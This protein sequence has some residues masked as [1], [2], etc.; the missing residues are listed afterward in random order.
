M[1]AV[2]LFGSI[3][4]LFLITR[5]LTV[6]FHELGHGIPALLLTDKTVTLYVGSYGDP[7]NSWRFKLGR[8]ECVFRYNPFWKIGMCVVDDTKFSFSRRIAI[9]LLGPI[10][11][12]VLGISCCYMAISAQLHGSIKLLSGALFLSCLL[13]FLINII[14][15]GNPVVLFDGKNTYNDGQ[16]LVHLFKFRSVPADARK[17]MGHYKN[18]E[19]E[20]AAK[21]FH[22]IINKGVHGETMLRL[23]IS[24]YLNCYRFEEAGE[25]HRELEAYYDLDSDDRTKSGLIHSRLG[26]FDQAL[27]EYDRALQLDP[28]NV[29]ALHNRGYTYSILERYDDAIADLDRAIEID[30][31]S[32]HAYSSRGMAKIKSKREMEGLQDIGTSLSIDDKHAYA[33]KSLGTYHFDRGEYSQ[34]LFFF[35]QAHALDMHTYAIAEDIRKTEEI[36]QNARDKG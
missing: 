26:N 17:A 36:M 6:L 11:S 1:A 13:D 32:A 34:A 23:T 7:D 3:I 30:S 27:M 12:L 14:P 16:Q 35:Q 21:L 24:A 28:E 33:Y 18:Q 29:Y 10:T 22:S 15:S 5:P 2:F 8:L 19:F 25:I 9:V 4:I 31:T 20:K